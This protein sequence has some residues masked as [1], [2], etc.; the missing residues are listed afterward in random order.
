M[1]EDKR[2]HFSGADD[3]PDGPLFQADA[4]NRRIEKIGRRVTVILILLPILFGLLLYYG[5]RDLS[6][7]MN[8]TQ[9]SGL[10]EVQKLSEEIL[11]KFNAVSAK[12]ENMETRLAATEESLQQTRSEFKENAA[13]STS[14]NASIASSA[15]SNTESIKSLNDELAALKTAKLDR[16]EFS[17]VDT[18]LEA[19]LIPL[20][21]DM[22]AIGELKEEIE[23][24]APLREEIDSLAAFR[25]ELEDVSGRLT[26]L[27]NSLGKDLNAFATYVEKTN[28][29]LVQ[30][31]SNIK[32][33]S[34]DK[35][36][37][38]K[39]RLELLK[40]GKSNRLALLKEITKIQKTLNTLQ[41]QI[42]KL[43]R[44]PPRSSII[45]PPSQNRGS[46]T[47]SQSDEVL[48]QELAD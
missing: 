42:D 46:A 31:E 13:T 20:K 15:Q 39:L 23:A 32:A 43:E 10:Q 41:G 8:R 19:A 44:T 37:Q 29:D 27:E 47:M 16:S 12:L 6:G 24:L 5:Y 45:R 14:T 48:E 9:D 17:Q 7:K 22:E 25:K 40:A 28:Q 38:E 18:K 3:V 30:I 35:I 36:G 11:E 21:K 33:L 1:A 26:A 34:K 2:F 4:K